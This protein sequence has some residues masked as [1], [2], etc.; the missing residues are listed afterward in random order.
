VTLCRALVA[1]YA[2]AMLGACAS[3]AGLSGG[4]DHGASDAGDSAAAGDSAPESTDSPSAMDAIN[5]D[6]PDD[7]ATVGEATGLP[8]CPPCPASFQ[9]VGAGCVGGTVTRCSAPFDLPDDID[10]AV[11][12]CPAAD[13]INACLVSG[14][15]PAASV[16]VGTHQA[17][18]NV[19]ATGSNPFIGTSDCSHLGSCNFSSTMAN[20]SVGPLQIVAVGTEPAAGACVTL[21]VHAASK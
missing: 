11:S 7:A 17:G 14:A 13:T 20:T 6:E 5:R 4:T 8:Q 3:L 21:I 18:Y 2:A 19:S 10:V 15:L 9:C 12:V 16:R 1:G